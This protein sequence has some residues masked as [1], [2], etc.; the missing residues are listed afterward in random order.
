MN[1][2]FLQIAENK[3]NKPTLKIGKKLSVKKWLHERIHRE[4]RD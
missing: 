4:K 2:F 3:K 1:S